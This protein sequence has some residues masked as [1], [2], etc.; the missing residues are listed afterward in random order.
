MMT[1]SNNVY[2]SAKVV[3]NSAEEAKYNLANFG[4][5]EFEQHDHG[6]QAQQQNQGTP[7][8]PSKSVEQIM[9][10]LQGVQQYLVDIQHRVTTIETEGV[11]GKD[12][13]KQIVQALK[14]LKNYSAFFEQSAFQLESKI[15]KTSI[16]I[17]QKIIG[18]EVGENSS[19]IAK[20]T[21]ES[22][23][24]KLQS[25]SKVTV[26]LH[27]KDYT[28][29]KNEINFGATV[30]LLEDPNVMQGG[31]VIASDLGNFDGSIEAKVKTLIYLSLYII[32]YLLFY[33]IIITNVTKKRA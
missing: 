4:A 18:I 20:Q 32:H 3:K 12:L 14:D 1:Q 16:A 8:Q 30:S 13:D 17:A 24:V 15:L 26:H 2:A 27:P 19:K 10:Q 22:L 6:V 21:L 33:D 11:R 9:A 25:A 31:V 5:D 29:L 28:V 23:M 7:A